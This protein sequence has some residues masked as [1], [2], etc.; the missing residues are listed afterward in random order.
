MKLEELKDLRNEVRVETMSTRKKS[1]DQDF[2]HK[3]GFR[4]QEQKT[5]RF[6]R[7]TPLNTLKSYLRGGT[8]STSQTYT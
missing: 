2:A 1:Y 3:G 8:S 6:M 7:Y 4:P 5:T